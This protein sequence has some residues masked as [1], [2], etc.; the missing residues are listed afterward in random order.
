MINYASEII[1]L[2]AGVDYSPTFIRTDKRRSA[3]EQTSLGYYQIGVLQQYGNA[4]GS[5][6]KVE[7]VDIE[8]GPATHIKIW[9]RENDDDN[10]PIYPISYL[11]SVN[12]T[13]LILLKKFIFCD[14][15]GNE[16]TGPTGTYL[17]NYT[18]YGHKRNT[19]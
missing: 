11:L 17:G 6:F 9:A 1:S 3:S 4:K 5:I 15:S 12:S 2:E 7:F 8:A 13:L 16:I 14:S 19:L 18:I 10:A